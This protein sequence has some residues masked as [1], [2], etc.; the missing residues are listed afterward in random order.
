[1]PRNITIRFKGTYSTL[2][3]IRRILRNTHNGFETDITRTDGR[4]IKQQYGGL[5]TSISVRRIPAGEV[6]A[7]RNLVTKVKVRRVPARKMDL[8]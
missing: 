1:M 5:V 4:V 8:I 6:V 2:Q 3:A 7:R